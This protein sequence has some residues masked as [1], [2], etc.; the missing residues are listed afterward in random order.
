M[1]SVVDICNLALGHLGDIASVTSID[2]PEGSAQ[3]EHCARFYPIA[4]DTLLEMHNWNFASRR[5]IPAQLT[6]TWPEW[7]YAYQVPSDIINMV[8]VL[9]PDAQDDY[10]TRWAPTDAPWTN[11]SPVVAAGRYVPQPYT[12]EVMAD[13]TQILYTNQKDA[14]L[15]YTQRV[16]DPTRFSPLFTLTLSWH[17][18]S[19]LAGPVIKGDMGQ[20]E[21]KRCAAVMAALLA[22]AESSDANQ[23]NIK[24]EHIVSWVSG[25]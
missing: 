10:S 25:R 18:A 15:R 20:A 2:P 22:Q 24:P 12:I 1:A 16:D 9:P 13:G 5:V 4:R 23:R 6:S 8:S 19:M 3:A 21:G 7:K 17:L 11:Y 14:V